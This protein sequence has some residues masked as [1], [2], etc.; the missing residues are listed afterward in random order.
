M[1]KTKPAEHSRKKS[2]PQRKTAVMHALKGAIMGLVITV[3]CVLIFAVIV[4]QSG[5]TDAAIAAV[6]QGIKIVSIFI[7]AFMAS[8]GMGKQ[9]AITGAM[10]GAIFIV[11]G[12][13]TFSL[14]DGQFGDIL[15]MFADLA[16]GLVIGMLTGIIFGKLLASTATPQVK[17]K[18]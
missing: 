1:Q 8:R 13:L 16:M 7:A 6:N 11:F 17:K 3:V 2:D 12:Y 4:K 10:A 14:I 5:A 9:A 18:A 15:M